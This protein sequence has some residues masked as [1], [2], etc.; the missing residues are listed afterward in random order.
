MINSDLVL[1]MKI[2]IAKNISSRENVKIEL[3]C[4]DFLS[5][6]NVCLFC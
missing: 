4:P 3:Y 6:A 5:M 2:H 1:L